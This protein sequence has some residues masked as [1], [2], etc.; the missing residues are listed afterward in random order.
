MRIHRLEFQAIGP[1]PGHHDIDFD[2]LSQAG[3]FLLTGPTGAGKSTVIDAIV[4]ALYGA[5]AGVQSDPAR[6]RCKLAAPGDASFVELTFSTGR[7]IYRV[8]RSPQYERPKQRGTGTTIEK[9]SVVLTRLSEAQ[10]GAS[11]ELLSTSQQEVGRQMLAIVGLSKDQFTQTAVLPQGQFAEFLHAKPEDRRKVLQQ[12]FSTGIYED[13]QTELTERAKEVRSRADRLATQVRTKIELVAGA[14]GQKESWR[15]YVTGL[16]D[17]SRTLEAVEVCAGLVADS[18]ATARAL[19]H[20]ER[21]AKRAKQAAD[22]AL[23][24]GQQTQQRQAR[25]AE[26]SAQ[27]RALVE[28]AEQVASQRG[29]LDSHRRAL[30]VF[31]A[32]QTHSNDRALLPAAQESWQEAQAAALLALSE[33]GIE[34]PD[35]TG[36][37]TDSAQQ[38]GQLR[39]AAV[40]RHGSLENAQQLEEALPR[41]TQQVAQAT[42]AVENA[43]AAYQQAAQTVA[44]LPAK[45]K[46]CEEELGQAN[47]QAALL[48]QA[49]LEVSE[50]ENAQKLADQHAKALAALQQADS[51]VESALVALESARRNQQH[52]LGAWLAGSASALAQQLQDGKPCLVCGSTEHPAPASGQSGAAGVSEE[53]VNAAAQRSEQAAS[54]HSAALAKQAACLEKVQELAGQ[55]AGVE[56]DS[57]ASRLEGAKAALGQAQRAGQRATTLQAEV[58]ELRDQHSALTERL[59][60]LEID[61]QTR[62]SELAFAEDSRATAVKSVQEARGQAQS[63]SAIRAELLAAASEAEAALALHKAWQDATAQAERSQEAVAQALAASGFATVE[64]ALAVVLPAER[65]SQL[66]TELQQYD[67]DLLKA[68]TALNQPE[69]V[70]AAAQPAPD[71]ESLQADAQAAA[72]QAD[73]AVSAAATAADAAGRVATAYLALREA[74]AQHQKAVAGAQSLLFVAAAVAGSGA[75]QKQIPLASFVLLSRF[76]EVLAAANPRILAISN[77]RYELARTDDEGGQRARLGGLGLAVIDHHTRDDAQRS[78]RTL[79]GGETFYFSLSLALALAEVVRQEAGGV[80]IGTL[81]IDEGF[82]S[83]DADTL[84]EVMNQISA[85]REGGRAVGLISHVAEMAQRI[86]DGIKVTRSRT[87]STLTVTAG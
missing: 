77:G 33:V 74:T 41:L 12:V 8:R 6:L 76:D 29:Q 26:L 28:R 5:L 83:L 57:L 67:T 68:E 75:N 23:S 86:P 27:R 60:Q 14:A 54:A 62:T 20:R 39:D 42:A 17:S 53:E 25:A 9:S 21:Q 16:F 59:H 51:S 73:A 81:F 36:S 49:Q 55:L 50:L 40:G 38:L 15:G 56:L 19:E 24:A 3:L 32:D 30:P 46:K 13:L 58:Q 72:D 71:L 11:G 22:A 7:G 37:A 4:F 69:L 85:L 10:P 78:P 70:A 44:A 2:S 52:T 43:K 35:S 18:G 80:E 64:G 31:Q 34:Q 1:F 47:A 87:G 65:A 82:G 79:S 66:E 61:I 63:V 84:D 45:T 48:G